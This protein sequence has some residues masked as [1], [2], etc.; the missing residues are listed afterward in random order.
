MKEAGLRGGRAGMQDSR[1]YAAYVLCV[2]A[3]ANGFNFLDR[4]ILAILLEPIR[5]ELG[6]SDT[7]LGFLSGPAFALFYALAGLPIARWVDRG[8]RRAIMAWGVALWSIMTAVCGLARSFVQLAIARTLVGVGEATQTPAAHSLISDYFEPRRRATA[9]AINSAGAN[10]GVLVGLALGGWLA[11]AYGWRMTFVAVGVPGLAVALLIRLTV[12]EPTRGSADGLSSSSDAGSFAEAARKLWSLRTY[13]HAALGASL[14]ALFGYSLVSWAPTFM[15][16]VHGWSAGEI[17]LPLG[18]VMGLGGAA[19]AITGGALS[20]RLGRRDPRWYTYLPAL[21]AIGMT[22]FAL[23]F[24][25]WPDG[26]GMLWYA[27]AVFLGTF[28]P[29]PCYALAQNL[30][31]PRMRGTSSAVMLLSITIIGLGVGPQLIGLLNDALAPRLG[32][33]AIRYSLSLVVLANLWASGHY[34]W[35]SRSVR[36]ELE[37]P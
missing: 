6:V 12:R 17:G 27:P 16:R 8:S 13:R 36:E 19:G 5:A 25:Y 22:P 4:Q 10:V 26:M 18:L 21:T 35:A 9:L 33:H 34:L 29:A 31:P 32:E 7:A 37:L 30:V 15:A 23:L 14:Q 20:D 3:L 2:F 11:D 1:R 24:L 28:Y